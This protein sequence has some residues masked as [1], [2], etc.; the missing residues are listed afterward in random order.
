MMWFMDDVKPV[1]VSSFGSDLQ[2]RPENKPAGA[3]HTCMLDC[4]ACIEEECMYSARKNYLE[5]EMHWMHYAFQHLQGRETPRED[6]HKSLLDPNNKFAR[7]VWDCEHDLVDHQTVIVNFEDGVTGTFVLIGGS[8]KAERNIHI[9]GTKGEI[10]GVFQ[11]SK[12]VIR[13]AAP[14]DT[15]EETRWLTAM[16]TFRLRW[17][18]ADV[19]SAL[20]ISILSMQ[21]QTCLLTMQSGQDAM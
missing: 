5:P 9:V 20:R 19:S 6:A 1:Q 16:V 12:Y 4:P 17:I 15:F 21:Q 7:C 10:K 3:G 11:D 13:K 2:F 14:N 8:A 18:F